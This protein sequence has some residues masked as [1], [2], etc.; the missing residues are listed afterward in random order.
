MYTP[1]ENNLWVEELLKD[2][3]VA[4]FGYADMSEI[5]PELRYNMPYGI[6]LA[7]K[8]EYMPSMT[9]MPSRE[10]H[11]FYYYS[12]RYLA[13]LTFILE[14]AI[15][16]RGYNAKTLVGEKFNR[17]NES[18]AL[19]HKTLATRAGLGWIGK[20]ACLVTKEYGPAVRIT[21]LVTDMPVK[22]GTPYNTSLCG[23]CTLCTT[24]CPGHAISGKLW[25]VN[26]A[27][28]EF[29]D[30]KACKDAIA[31]R[32]KAIG[33]TNG[34]CGICVGICP[35][36]RKSWTPPKPDE[37]IPVLPADPNNPHIPLLK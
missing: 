37:R 26:T 3:H 16:E 1:E 14:K 15:K 30:F 23:S 25:D 10:F 17:E 11:D 21:G 9:D 28:E 4:L 8:L 27:R 24:H 22:T 19:P 18:V 6:C 13:Q 5:D 29:Y 12:N 2:K 34:A 32:G 36:T 31:E 20:S 33:V 7:V 35:Y